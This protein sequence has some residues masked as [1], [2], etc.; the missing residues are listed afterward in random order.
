MGDGRGV[1]ELHLPELTD[2]SEAATPGKSSCVEC[3]VGN[4]HLDDFVAEFPGSIN[5][6]LDESGAGALAKVVG[7][8]GAF[9]DDAFQGRLKVGDEVAD[10]R[11]AIEG[12]EYVTFG[13]DGGLSEPDGEVFG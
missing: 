1:V 7:M 13:V 9:E 3:C 8:D 12:E 11:V 2:E 10:G 5:G 4:G 6:C